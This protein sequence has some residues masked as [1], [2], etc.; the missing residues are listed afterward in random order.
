MVKKD[1]GFGFCG[2]GRGGIG[3]AN[4]FLGKTI[5]TPN[6]ENKRRRTKKRTMSCVGIDQQ[7]KGNCNAFP[8]Q[9][10]KKKKKKTELV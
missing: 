4:L 8:E 10:K 6:S 9:K 3:R 1:G 2:Y 5:H 7:R